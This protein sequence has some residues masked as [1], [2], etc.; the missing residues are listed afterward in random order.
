MARAL[1]RPGLFTEQPC[2]ALQFA[3]KVVFLKSP[4]G[5]HYCCCIPLCIGHTLL[6]MYNNVYSI[7]A[8]FQSVP[9]EVTRD[10]M[11]T[12]LHNRALVLEAA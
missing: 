4:S 3:V 2:L 1:H 9:D 11:Y 5:A 8:Y 7:N 6:V 10:E 12:T